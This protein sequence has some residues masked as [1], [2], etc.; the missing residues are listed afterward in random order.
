MKVLAKFKKD[1]L[2]SGMLTLAFGSAGAKALTF[3]L[4]PFITRIYSPDEYGVLSIYTAIIICIAPLISLR[5]INAVNIAKNDIEAINIFCCSISLILLFSIFTFSGLYIS[6]K[7]LNVFDTSLFQKFWW[8]IALGIIGS[9]INEALMLW[10]TRKKNYKAISL[11]QFNQSL[12]GGISKIIL[13]LIGLSSLGLLLGQYIQQTAGL[14]KMFSIFKLEFF[15]LK[16]KI[17]FKRVVYCYKKYRV[18]PLYRLPSHALMLITLQ[19]PIFYFAYAFTAEETGQMALA[20]MVLSI[21]AQVLG[22]AMSYAYLGE[23]GSI[24]LIEKEKIRKL[25]YK[26]ISRMAMLGFFPALLIFL[27]G[28]QLFS[29]VFG[30]AWEIAGSY[31]SIMSFFLYLKFVTTPTMHLFTKINRQDLFFK[32]NFSRFFIL[33]IAGALAYYNGVNAYTAVLVFSLVMSSHYIITFV[34]VFMTVKK[35]SKYEE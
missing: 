16:K 8:L 14:F 5:Y 32:L 25:T 3:L 21:P 6:T 30:K 10:S 34:C 22:T 18:F 17:T 12:Y 4:M 31:A 28:N 19:A 20:M 2:L 7:V 26:V 1:T 29:L 11:V 15:K 24:N 9:A 23:V 33:L 13:G 27:Y 35:W